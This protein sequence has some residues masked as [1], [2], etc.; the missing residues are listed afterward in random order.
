M[1][2]TV[3]K[4][5]TVVEQIHHDLGPTPEQPV[6]KGAVAAVISNPYVG[7]YVHDLSPVFDEFKALGEH[8]G[9]M[10]IGQMGGDPTAIDGYGKGII[11]G[12]AGEIEHGA[13]WHIP[14]GA[15]MRAALGKGTSIVPSTKKVAGIGARLDVPITHLEWSYVGSHYDAIEVGVPDGPKPDEMVVILAMASGGRVHARLA[16]G[17]TLADR[18]KPG[19]PA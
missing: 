18:G 19:V 9:T 16:G 4:Y 12:S 15:G 17:F 14:G 8:M 1:L 11:V 6:L 13:M 3:R 2:F 7:Q 10:L 5:L